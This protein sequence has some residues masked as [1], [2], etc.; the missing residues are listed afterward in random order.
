MR[1]DPPAPPPSPIA[2]RAMRRTRR[3]GDEFAVPEDGQSEESAATNASQ[4]APAL[5]GLTCLLAQDAA[6]AP[7]GADAGEA[8]RAAVGQ[9]RALLGALAGLQIAALGGDGVQARQTLAD[10]ARALPESADPGLDAVLRAIAQRAA[11]ELAR[12]G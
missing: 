3:P 11:I 12:A 7:A 2:S 9:G 10:L 1:I 5:V 4:Q 6:A 8:A